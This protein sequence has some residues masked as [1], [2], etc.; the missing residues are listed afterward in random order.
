MPREKILPRFHRPAAK[1]EPRELMTL[2]RSKKRLVIALFMALL[3]FS[4]C[5]SAVTDSSGAV[6]FEEQKDASQQPQIRQIGSE[7][8]TEMQTSGAN[9]LYELIGVYPNSYNIFFT[10]YETCQ[11]I[12]LCSRPECTHNNESCTSFVD[13]KAGNIPGLLYANDTLYLISPASVN[14]NFLPVIERLNPDGSER[15]ILAQF[16]ASQNLN[17]GWFLADA[18]SLYFIMEDINS[19][20]SFSKTLCAINTENGTVKNILE[21][22]PDTWIMDG[23]E[24]S[25]YLKTIEQGAAPERDLFET[26]EA[27]LEAFLNSDV[28]KI[29][30]VS[31]KDTSDQI[32]VDEWRQSERIASMQ[33]GCLYFYDTQNN[34]FVKRN[35]ET[36]IDRVVPN[37]METTPKSLYFTNLIDQKLIF[38]SITNQNGTEVS[39]SNF[40][41]D[42]ELNLMKEIE[43][44]NSMNR[45]VKICGT[46]G[47][48]LFV[49]YDAINQTV[50]AEK[51]GVV[52]EFT[53]IRLQ[54]GKISKEDFF[55]GKP[56]YTACSLAA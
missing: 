38:T 2:K 45:P 47:D 18:T 31:V 19:D 30:R 51:D 17:T 52:E 16:K 14:E 3:S 11:Q 43:L 53:Q 21:C 8:G 1:K 42:F 55:N 56:N 32:I 49:Q 29:I 48:S 39:V 12:Y 7:G 23:G 33:Q 5:G 20:G 46:F 26:E 13:C 6:P 41:I 15:K 28:H 4:S 27:F 54:L 35:Y 50:Q 22:A 37:T 34:E 36:S 24:Q 9:G 44:L 10:D 25:I 40:F